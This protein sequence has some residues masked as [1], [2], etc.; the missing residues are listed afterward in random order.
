MS[1]Y[2]RRLNIKWFATTKLGIEELAKNTD[3]S[4]TASDFRLLFY[5]L[6]K[7]DEDNR[8]TL[9]KQKDISTEINISVRKISEGLRRLHEAK[10]IV[11][12]DEPKTYFINPAFFYTGGAQVLEPKQ[13]D[14]DN[15]FN[16]QVETYTPIA[17]AAEQERQL[18]DLLN[19]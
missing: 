12:S 17:D 1:I 5:L 13:E 3:F 15:R 19:T 11:K 8:A 16:P 6:S 2:K 10:I 4:L 18:K 7:I 9:P 14:F